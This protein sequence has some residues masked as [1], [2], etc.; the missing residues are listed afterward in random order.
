MLAFILNV[1]IILIIMKIFFK[2]MYPRPPADFFPKDG[3]DTT[4][5]VC[6][7][8][9]HSLPTYR[10]ILNERGFFCNDGHE[11]AFIITE[12]TDK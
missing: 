6:N 3:D 5:R 10:G 12:D 8:C 7:Y 2:F 4:L 1:I 9:G 11:Q